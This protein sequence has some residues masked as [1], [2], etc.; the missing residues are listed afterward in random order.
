MF[1]KLLVGILTTLLLLPCNV[2]DAGRRGFLGNFAFNNACGF[3]GLRAQRFRL[4]RARAIRVPLRVQR[5]QAL[6]GGCA[7]QQFG[8]AQQQFGCAQQQ[9]GCVQQQFGCVQQQLVRQQ[10]FQCVQQVQQIKQFAVQPQF[11]LQPQFV[12][13]QV[14][15]FNAPCNQQFIQ[16][17]IQA[18]NAG[19]G[20]QQFSQ[21]V[22]VAPIVHGQQFTSPAPVVVNQVPVVAK[23]IQAP[24]VSVINGASTTAY[25]QAVPSIGLPVEPVRKLLGP[26]APSVKSSGHEDTRT[27]FSLVKDHTAFVKLNLPCK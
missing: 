15:A 20:G 23:P 1:K 5:R 2:A 10:Q 8:C 11:A 7:Q 25:P 3:Q 17:P 9:L 14:Q 27:G 12:K 26:P 4:R 19:Y 18:F 21:A 24:V 22:N 13:Q 6:F 16:Q